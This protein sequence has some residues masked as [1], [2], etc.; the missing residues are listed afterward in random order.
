MKILFGG[1]PFNLLSNMQEF[2]NAFFFPI[3]IWLHLFLENTDVWTTEQEI[4]W[5]AHN[6]YELIRIKG[7]RYVLRD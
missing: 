7:D 6:P 1:N 4:D 2:F 5:L 3:A